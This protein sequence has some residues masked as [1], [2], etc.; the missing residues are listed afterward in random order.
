MFMMCVMSTNT[1]PTD[2]ETPC[3]SQVLVQ[4]GHARFYK[5]SMAGLLA[6]TALFW[7][8]SKAEALTETETLDAA[9]VVA[10]AGFQITVTPEAAFDAPR[11]YRSR[12][13]QIAAEQG[14][15]TPAVYKASVE[16][17]VLRMRPTVRTALA[18][19]RMRATVQPAVVRTW[20][21]PEMAA[22][23]ATSPRAGAAPDVFGSVAISIGRTSMDAKWRSVAHTPVNNS[24]AGEILSRIRGESASSQLQK[25]NIWVN[26]QIDFTDDYRS[27]AADVWANANESL[28]SG[29]GDCED[30][31][32]AKLQI[33]R[34]AGYDERDLYLVVVRDLVR[35]ADHAVLVVRLDAG[36]VV[37]DSNTDLI[38][39]AEAAHDYKPLMSFSGEKSWTHGYRT[40]T[41]QIIL[42][43][44]TA[45]PSPEPERSF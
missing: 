11:V 12:L 28:R 15:A 7:S 30:Y 31:A 32:I 5:V 27:G 38:V 26:R 43:S 17:P 40:P 14:E 6:A 19:P 13:E 1:Q 45:E 41:P 10:D 16:E 42:A 3:P 20:T 35:R 34:A 37:L 8:G 44:T 21:A 22:P 25:V 33:L 2:L 24:V 4:G 39:A 29:A 9:E 36:F 23:L 18:E